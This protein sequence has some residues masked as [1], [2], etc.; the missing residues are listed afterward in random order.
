M[1][2]RTIASL[3]IAVLLGLLAVIMVRNV[4]ASNAAKGP[5]AVSAAMTPVVVAALPIERG[6]SLKPA[7]LRVV[8]YP[9]NAVP[10]GAFKTIEQVAGAANART[11]M[12]SMTANEPVLNDKLSGA[13]GKTNLSGSLTPG[14]RAVSVRSDEVNGVGGFVL[15]GDRV[16]ILL[17][18]TVGAGAAETTVTQVLAENS[19]VLG[20]D[21]SSDVE[22]NKPLV[23]RSVTVE[24]TPDQAQTISLAH[25]VGAIS[26]SLRQIS[27]KEALARKA[28]TVA[29][30]GGFGRKAVATAAKPKPKRP[31]TEVRVTRGVETIGYAVGG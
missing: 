6:V 7:M 21:Q 20:V 13:G 17:T 4:M 27:D 26:L 15:P 8:D 29:D 28:T 2:L 25:S 30:L 24:V 12:R 10:A 14:M 18:R 16:D 19:L 1:S 9:N 11:A 5:G 23:A 31:G 22:A 3:A